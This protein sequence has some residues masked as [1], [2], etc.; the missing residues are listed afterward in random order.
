MRI[1][2]NTDIFTWLLDLK[3][4]MSYVML[5]VVSKGNLK[6]IWMHHVLDICDKK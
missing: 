2:Y 4:V 3:D 5:T 6:D 1:A